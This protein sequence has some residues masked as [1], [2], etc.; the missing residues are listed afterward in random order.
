MGY[1]INFRQLPVISNPNSNLVL[2]LVGTLLDTN[3]GLY[4]TVGG[5]RRCLVACA[6]QMF[7]T[8]N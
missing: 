8:V 3:T 1:L 5:A 6:D 4:A 7:K 2:V